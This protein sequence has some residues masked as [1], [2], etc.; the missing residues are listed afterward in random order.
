VPLR[1]SEL[2]MHAQVCLA[3]YG[4]DTPRVE[5]KQDRLS[6]SEG[7][8]I[9][10]SFRQTLRN[11]IHDQSNEASIAANSGQLSDKLREAS[12]SRGYG[13]Q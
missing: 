13:P 2:E 1:N 7:D 8:R 12:R 9:V 11:Y 10:D 6:P 4:I 5:I 3:F